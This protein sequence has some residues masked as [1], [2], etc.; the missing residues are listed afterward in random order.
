MSDPCRNFEIVV[1]K[2]S[3]LVASYSSGK[4]LLASSFSHFASS[5]NNMWRTLDN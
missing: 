2:S 1:T 3:Q 5:K 4:G